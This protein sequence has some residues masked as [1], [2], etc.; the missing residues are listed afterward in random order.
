MFRRRIFHLRLRSET[1]TLGR[2]TLL[3]GVLNIPP[4]SFSAGA[5]F[6][7]PRKAAVHA[8]ALE[9][10][11]ADIIDIGAESTRPG[12]HGITAAEELRRLLPVLEALRERLN[13][14]ISVDT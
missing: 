10:N 9:K 1:L 4:D 14:P 2:R 8:L 3:M 11:G 6:L 13:V 5:Q 7:A 12:S